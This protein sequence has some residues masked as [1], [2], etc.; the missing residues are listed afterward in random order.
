MSHEGISFGDI[1]IPLKDVQDLAMHG[2]YA[3]VLSVQ[4]DYYEILI[5]Q[6]ENALKFFL[7][8]KEYAKIPEAVAV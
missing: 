3:L 7:L 5:P 1:R 8:Y 4:K 6:E 2:K